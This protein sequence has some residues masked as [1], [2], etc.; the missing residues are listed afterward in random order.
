MP[1]SRGPILTG[2]AAALGSVLVEG[3]T[4]MTVDLDLSATTETVNI[5]ASE[6]GTNFNTA[7][8][9]P[10]DMSTGAVYASGDMKDG[11]FSVDVAGLYTVKFT[12]SSTSETATIRIGF[13]K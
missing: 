6:D 9:R 2:T 1:Y 13:F 8:L 12:K 7:K 11:L 10:I 5:T 3:Y 4:K